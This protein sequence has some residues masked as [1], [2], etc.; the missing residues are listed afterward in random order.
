MKEERQTPLVSINPKDLRI[1]C[2]GGAVGGQRVG[3][4]NGVR[5]TH[6]PSG[7]VTECITERSQHK[8]RNAALKELEELVYVWEGSKVSEPHPDD[9]AVDKFAAMMKAKLAKSRE[10]GRSGWDDPEQCSTK[11]LA[12]LLVSHV[13]KGDPVDIANLAMMLALREADPALLKDAFEGEAMA[14][15]EREGWSSGG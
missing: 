11:R 2:Y 1:D 15:M 7:I 9:F 4:A 8:N 6:I 5:I 13:P 12:N 10:K 14:M 3:M